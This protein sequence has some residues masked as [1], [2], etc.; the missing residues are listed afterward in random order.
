MPTKN[1]IIGLVFAVII[2]VSGFYI[3]SPGDDSQTNSNKDNV[4]ISDGK[5]IIQIDARGGYAPRVSVA[6]AD[7]PT[8]IRVVTNGTYDC[9]AGLVIPSIN[10]KKILP[11]TGSTDI[12]IPPQKAG[13]SLKGLCSM[14]MYN[15]AIQF[16]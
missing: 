10:Y 11:P 13:T 8:I 16:N 4:T 5:Q 3:L 6:S 7:M 1:I 2:I 14:G 9:S 12:E 15:F